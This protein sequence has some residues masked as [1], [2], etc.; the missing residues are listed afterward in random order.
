MDT[1]VP[2]AQKN[3]IITIPVMDALNVPI[4]K[5]EVYDLLLPVLDNF[6]IAEETGLTKVDGDVFDYP[7]IHIAYSGEKA[8]SS[9][10]SDYFTGLLGGRPAYVSPH[11]RRDTAA[12]Y[13]LKE[14]KEFLRYNFASYH[15][16]IVRAKNNQG[17]GIKK[18]KAEAAR[19]KDVAAMEEL[20]M[21][22][23]EIARELA[24]VPVVDEEVKKQQYVRS[25][26]MDLE[27]T[28]NE[29]KKTLVYTVDFEAKQARVCR[30]GK[31]TIFEGRRGIWLYGPSRC[32]K[33]YQ[34]RQMLKK[35]NGYELSDPDNWDG[36][37]GQQLI[38]LNEFSGRGHFKDPSE[39]RCFIDRARQ[40][41]KYGSKL[42]DPDDTFFIV[43]S[44]YTIRE[45]YANVLRQDFE[46]WE[47]TI[48]ALEA[49]F[50]Q[51]KFEHVW[52][53][54]GV[55]TYN[56]SMWTFNSSDEEDVPKKKA[57]VYP[58]KY[59][60]EVAACQR[61]VMAGDAMITCENGTWMRSI[62]IGDRWFAKTLLPN[63]DWRQEEI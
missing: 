40:N 5:K 35:F 43:T 16:D 34:G 45:I 58:S 47:P 15:E 26:V 37:N 33:T 30:K 31:T 36:Y 17:K 61:L 10:D 42:T 14:D 18:Q 41:R 8:Y 20:N 63:G 28:D 11:P 46:M 48:Q 29:T 51:L 57:K 21:L 13:V 1:G 22:P 32:G 27:F 3:G 2:K 25:N 59:E 50:F 7:H 56:P 24:A 49:V 52:K 62:K 39:F 55:V 23:N 12:V 60:E 53:K 6:I 44:N 4:T 9:R 38:L 54:E 19:T